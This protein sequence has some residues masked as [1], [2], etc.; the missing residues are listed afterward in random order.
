MTEYA[1]LSMYNVHSVYFLHPLFVDIFSPSSV[2]GYFFSIIC[3]WIFFLHQ[4][5]VDI[6]SPFLRSTG[7]PSLIP[8]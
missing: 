5:F 2:C 4:L 3:L 8:S 7:S 1:C 6:F